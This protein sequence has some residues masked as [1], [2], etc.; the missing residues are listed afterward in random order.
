MRRTDKQITGLD[1]IIEI[2]NDCRVCRI[3]LS[4][5]NMPYIVPMNFGFELAEEKLVLYF[6]C[7]REGKK[8]D[9]IMKN[10]KACFEMDTAHELIESDNPCNYG[11]KYKSLIGFGNVEFIESKAEKELALNFIM[12]K[13]TGNFDYKFNDNAVNLTTVFKIETTE[14]TAKGN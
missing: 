9:V 12:K 2:L 11:F 10:P 1:G 8:I 5:E 6:H 13:H 4:F 3:G 14:Y 7:A